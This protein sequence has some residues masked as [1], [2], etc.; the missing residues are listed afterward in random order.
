MKTT[1]SL[2]FG[3]ILLLCSMFAHSQSA[4]LIISQHR[5]ER[6]DSV[7]RVE[8][9]SRYNERQLRRIAAE[10]VHIVALR[11][12]EKFLSAREACGLPTPMETLLKIEREE[13]PRIVESLA[14]EAHRCVEVMN[15]ST[16]S[17]CVRWADLP[18]PRTQH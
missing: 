2:I 9:R 16:G 5:N 1:S 13:M 14:P 15:T 4:C 11:K 10:G 6:I 3:G 7:G 8:Y 12:S 18:D 17:E